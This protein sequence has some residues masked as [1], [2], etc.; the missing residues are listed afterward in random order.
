MAVLEVDEIAEFTASARG[1]LQRV[2]PAA[3]VSGEPDAGGDRLRAVWETAA[4]Q[5]WTDLGREDLLD[6]AIA[7]MREL[8]AV[9]CPLPI[10]DVYVASRLF[11][12][13][14]VADEIAAGA[15]RPV[16]VAGAEDRRFVEAAGA[17]THVLV[18]PAGAGTAELRALTGGTPTEGLARPAWSDVELGEVAA[19]VAVDAAAV[20]GA[21]VTLRL[22]LVARAVAA[23]ERSHALALAHASDRMQFGKPIGSYQAVQHRAVDGA[24]DVAA[25][26]A[27]VDEAVRR[28]ASTHGSWRLAAEIAVAFGTRVAPNVQFGAH[29]TLAAI[30]Y[31]E[32]HPAPWLF[33][34]VHADV[35]RVALFPLAAGELADQL[36]EG[37]QGLP[38]LDLGPAAEALRTRFRDDLATLWKDE[39]SKR[40]SGM[41]MDDE[42]TEALAER[43]YFTLGWPKEHGGAEATIEEQAAVQEESQYRGLPVGQA[44][45]AANLLGASIMRHG[46]AEQKERYL[47]QIAQ[48]RM[49]FYLGYSEPE[50]GSDLASVQ[51][52]AVRDGD[53]WVINGAKMWGT[54]AQHADYVWLATRTDPDAKPRHAGITVFLLPTK[55]PGWDI[56][57]HVALSGEISCTTFFDD[58][59]VPDSMR[60]GDVNGG[61]KVITDALAAERVEMAGV[62]AQLLRQLDELL[63]VVREDPERLIGGR[64][65]AK[66]ALLTEVASRLQAAR[67]LTTVSLRATAG[68]GG[69]RLEAP[70]A[71]IL[72]SE[73][74]EAFGEAALS[75]LGPAATLSAGQP[76]VPGG[77]AFEYGLRWSIMQVVGGGTADIQRNLVARAL[78]MPR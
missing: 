38:D 3:E 58:V 74:S 63:A 4:E 5:G 43:G 11:A 15:V 54:G 10:I 13:D 78:G 31:F 26:R 37:S 67:A 73:L 35:S 47:P 44:R 21:R 18:L 40:G 32:E 41:E 53:E 48:G 24:A 9:A 57:E 16:V 70:M 42:L 56:Q 22:G 33:R 34:R 46:S 71:K 62:S 28:Y 6:A 45:G 7:T 49:R 65:S 68:G 39:G 23:A 75:I 25:T 12:D 51:T 77:G 50:V 1:A 64:G 14:A 60:V 72:A 36:V 30:G 2:W 52:R 19:S 55:L 17:A 61:W 69:A 8:G 29:H 59:R 27:L 76:G 66:R 20:E